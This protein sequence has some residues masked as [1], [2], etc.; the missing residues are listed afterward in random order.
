YRDLRADLLLLVRRVEGADP[1]DGLRGTLR[2]QRGEDEVTGL[3]RG[4]RGRHGLQVAQLADQDDV[5]V[6]AQR[7]LEGGGERAGIRPDFAL[8]DQ[9]ALVRV[10]ELDRVLDGDDVRVA[11]PVGQVQQGGEGGGLAGA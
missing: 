3:R 10:E 7:V 6:L 8:V 1:V 4:Q 5:R 2:V 9:A 11:G